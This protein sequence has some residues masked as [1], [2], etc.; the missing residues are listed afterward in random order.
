MVYEEILAA[1]CSSS[2]S[3]SLPREYK[4]P[5]RESKST[6]PGEV[7]AVHLLR[8]S[9]KINEEASLV[10]YTQSLFV[11]LNK[12][13]RSSRRGMTMDLSLFFAAAQFEKNPSGAV[14]LGQSFRRKLI[15]DVAKTFKPKREQL[16]LWLFGGYY[17]QCEPVPGRTAKAGLPK[18]PGPFPGFIF[19]AFLRE[20]GL[21]N[22]AKIKNLEF[23]FPCLS[24][25]CHDFPIYAEIV[26]QHIFGLKKLS[27]RKF[28]VSYLQLR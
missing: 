14:E 13:S 12:N 2:P 16:P 21:S 8:T 6:E 22:T 4:K 1:S 17:I 18:S 11:A 23:V 9:K 7:P 5:S 26:R 27:I 3:L 24:Q 28:P 19:P 10:L 15:S 20:I 25:A